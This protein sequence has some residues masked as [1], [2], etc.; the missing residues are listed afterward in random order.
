MVTKLQAAKLATASGTDVVIAS[1]RE[2]NALERL[3]A[4]ERLGTFFPATSDRLESRKRWMLSGLSTRGKIIIDAGAEKA[5]C[6]Q[7]KSLLPAGVKA[8]EGRF[9]RGDTVAICTEDGRRIAVGISNYGHEDVAAIRGLRS[10]RIAQVLGFEY[11]AEVVHRNNLV[12]L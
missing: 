3:A 12:L 10:D 2:P 1:G 6:T 9:Q 4:G 7:G 8:V 11:G 5:L